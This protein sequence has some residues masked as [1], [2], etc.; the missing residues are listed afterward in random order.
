MSET[1]ISNDVRTPE[2]IGAAARGVS[3]Q[4]MIVGSY[5][6]AASD[7]SRPPVTGRAPSS[8]GGEH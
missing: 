2:T 1:Y 3:M 4:D 5:R 6:S 8:N 7:A